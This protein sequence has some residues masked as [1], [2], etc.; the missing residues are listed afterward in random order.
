M[1]PDARREW[2]D[3]RTALAEGNS[4]WHQYTVYVDLY[5][6]YL[7]IAWKGSVW[8]FATVGVILTFLFANIGGP[9]ARAL[10][11]VLVF[12]AMLSFGFAAL[13]FRTVFLLREL[14]IFLDHI[15]GELHLVGRPHVE[16]M[17]FFALLVTAF[18][19]AIGAGSLIFLG[20]YFF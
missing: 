6:F 10:P 16:F 7:D 18:S 4:L 17:Q 14:A 2:A 9:D 12:V 19:T 11:L 3:S 13:Y 15:A 8:Y 1:S 20:L 5:R